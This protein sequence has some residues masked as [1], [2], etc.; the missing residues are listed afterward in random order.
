MLPGRGS[1]RW[2]RPESKTFCG[3]LWAAWRNR[4][5][6]IAQQ[7]QIPNIN[8]LLASGIVFALASLAC[9]FFWTYRLPHI[10][11]TDL[12][13]KA[14]AWERNTQDGAQ[15]GVVY[16]KIRVRTGKRTFD[17]AVYRDLTGCRQ[18]K[19][20]QLSAEEQQLRGK[21]EIAGVDWEQP[22]SVAG[23]ESWRNRQSIRHESVTRTSKNL[24]TLTTST[25]TTGSSITQETLT[26]RESD[27]H[28]V[29]RS[30]TYRDSETVEIAELNYDVLPWRTV[31]DSLFE[32]KEKG[33]GARLSSHPA[34]LPRALSESE[35]DLAELSARLVLNRLQADSGE[36]IEVVRTPRGVLV[37]GVVETDQRKREI[38]A[39]LHL[40]ANVDSAIASYRELDNQPSAGSEI[41]RVRLSSM[42]AQ[43]TSLEKYLADRRW[44]KD[45]ISKASHQIF[46]ASVTI[47]RESRA[48]TDLLQRFAL[49]GGRGITA[50]A[51]L[52][53]LISAHKSRLLDALNQQDLS[54]AAVGLKASVGNARSAESLL[55]DAQRNANLS[56]ELIST[57]EQP[58][59]AEIIAWDLSSSVVQLQSDLLHLS[60]VTQPTHG[61]AG[62]LKT[63]GQKEKE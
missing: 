42:A 38:E 6:V 29:G 7:M 53:Q 59:S 5:R 58:R 15:T 63:P 51:A 61:L 3:S 21:L 2:R 46:K 47:E 12:L 13:Y 49:G 9:L 16:Q 33:S 44:L 27:F 56:R 45:D 17:R 34:Y 23:Y 36:R 24:L 8:P 26:V 20:Q 41:N 37:K 19:R 30:I 14:K 28:P 35:L 18:P 10:P 48:I 55:A 25:V 22:L 57:A 11:P 39:Q 40:I 52:E 4:L 62:S 31:N 54:L 32:A 60:L 43:S 50:D 1:W